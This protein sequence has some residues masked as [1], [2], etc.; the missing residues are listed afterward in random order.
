MRWNFRKVADSNMRLV[1]FWVKVKVTVRLFNMRHMT[2]NL[3]V[4][5][6]ERTLLTYFTDTVVCRGESSDQAHS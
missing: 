4:N 2:Y 6:I 5:D 1:R 3:A